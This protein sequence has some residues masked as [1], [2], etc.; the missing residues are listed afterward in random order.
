MLL[1]ITYLSVALALLAVLLSAIVVATR[2]LRSRR[3]NERAQRHKQLAEKIFAALA[4]DRL[5]SDGSKWSP[6]SWRL[7]HLLSRHPQE[8]VDVIVEIAESISGEDRRRL[9]SIA[10]RAGIFRWLSGEARQPTR[11]RRRAAIDALRLSPPRYENELRRALTDSWDEI[12]AIALL[13]LS[14]RGSLAPD[15][16]ALLQLSDVVERRPLTLKRLFESLAMRSSETITPIAR[17]ELGDQRLQLLAIDALSVA[18]HTSFTGD[19]LR[20]AHDPEREVRAAAYRALGRLGD[21]SFEEAFRRGLSDPEWEVRVSAVNAVAASS[22]TS[23]T[24]EI[25]ELVSDDAWWVSFRASQALLG[26]SEKGLE[27]L[28]ALAS[29][30]E[31]KAGAM[32][33][34]V[35]S[36]RHAA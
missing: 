33:E 36:R 26:F 10:D 12:R 8:S 29:L 6:A 35:L 17:G 20:L 11:H 22:M 18:R 32:A 5:D 27:A 2:S 16:K 34:S 3:E 21:P 19:F 1:T 24:P 9:I 25:I 4:D 23:L 14:E 13:E 30:P 7:E 31:T 15:P 28:K